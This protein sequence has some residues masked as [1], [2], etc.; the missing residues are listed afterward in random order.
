MNLSYT[1]PGKA[2]FVWTDTVFLVNTPAGWRVDD[3][4][5]G[6]TWDFGNKGSL[7]ETLKQVIGFQ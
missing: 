5:F 6:G 4:A 2:P 7:S 3:I 1:E